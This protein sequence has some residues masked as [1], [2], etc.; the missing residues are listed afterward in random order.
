MVKAACHYTRACCCIDPICL[1]SESRKFKSTAALPV[2][3]LL[4]NAN[5]AA[6]NVRNK[7]GDLPLHGACRCMK[8]LE[9]LQ[10]LVDDTK[11]AA[12]SASD[13]RPLPLHFAILSSSPLDVIQRIMEIDPTAVSVINEN[14]DLPL[15]LACQCK[16][17]L[18]LFHLLLEK[19]GAATEIANNQGFCPL[20]LAC[21]CD[22]S[23]D[24]LLLLL[25]YN[26]LVLNKLLNENHAVLKNFLH[27]VISLF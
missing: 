12:R 2:V 4:R 21:N 26:P 22:A 24:T 8:S 5:P 13:K 17:P 11:P 20:Q 18:E 10:V 9:F 15:H 6:V 14:G 25:K 23:L 27:E 1:G 3:K 16:A 19:N 7:W